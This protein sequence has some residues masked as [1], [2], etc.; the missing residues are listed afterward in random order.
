MPLNCAVLPLFCMMLVVCVC[1]YVTACICCLCIDF[2]GVF[3]CGVLLFSCFCL[4]AFDVCV[5]SVVC[6]VAVCCF[7]GLSCVYVLR[8]VLLVCFRFLCFVMV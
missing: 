1:V 5:L 8:L 3:V 6:A 2:I 7:I 4:F